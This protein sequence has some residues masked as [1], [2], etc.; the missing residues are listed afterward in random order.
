MVA[1]IIDLIGVSLSETHNSRNALQD[2]RVC[3]CLLACGVQNETVSINQSAT[4]VVDLDCL[5]HPDDIKKD[6]F[7]KWNY[8]GSHVLH[9][10]MGK[11]PGG[12]LVLERVLP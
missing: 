5:E 8:S 3:T 11:T 12:K 10:Q 6:D 9:Y 4:Y 7:G 1:P 2:A